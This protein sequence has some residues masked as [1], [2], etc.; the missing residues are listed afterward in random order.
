MIDDSDISEHENESAIWIAMSDL[1][2]GLMAIFLVMSMMVLINQQ[3][4][5]KRLIDAM[6]SL[7]QKNEKIKNQIDSESRMRIILIQTIRNALNKSNIQ[8]FTDPITGDVSIINQDLLFDNAS[9]QLSPEGKLFLD[10]FVPS[11]TRAIFGLDSSV[12]DEVV[13]VV[14]EGRTSS[15]GD[16]S[17]NT[18]LSLNRANAVVQ[19]IYRMPSFFGQIAMVRRLTPV[20]R[21]EM[22]AEQRFDNPN[23]REVIFRFQFKGELLNREKT[24]HQFTQDLQNTSAGS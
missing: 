3:R 24:S 21:G 15:L 5:T 19:Y 4:D 23:N 14:V 20:G 13:R 10:R 16:A 22:E 11:Y 18:T 8:A 12:S 1:M 17:K 9:D 2:T 7:K 6:A